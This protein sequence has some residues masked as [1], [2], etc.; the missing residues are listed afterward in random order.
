[1]NK[2]NNLVYVIEMQCISYD[3]QIIFLIIFI[4]MPQFKGLSLVQV[5]QNQHV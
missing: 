5:Q 4:W 1:M 3:V 2:D